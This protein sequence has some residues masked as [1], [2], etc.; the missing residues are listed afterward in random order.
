MSGKI[1]I[2]DFKGSKKTHKKKTNIYNRDQGQSHQPSKHGS[3]ESDQNTSSNRRSFQEEEY[4]QVNPHNPVNN[5]VEE[6]NQNPEQENRYSHKNQQQN[7][8]NEEYVLRLEKDISELKEENNSLKNEIGDW[9]NKLSRLNNEL[10]NITKQNELDLAQAKKKSK[11]SVISQLLEFINTLHLAFLNLPKEQTPET[12]KFVNTLQ[13]SFQRLIS[14]L[15]ADNIE[16]IFPEPGQEFD[17]HYMALLEGTQ[18]L[19]EHPKVKQVVSLGAKID[20]QV[21]KPATVIA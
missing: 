14:D 3:E 15:Q 9:Q 8:L 13:T 10:N 2:D 16:I 5:E 19:E 20:D 7:P 18:I 17:P 4:E 1:K 6:L 11:K 12:Q 21:I